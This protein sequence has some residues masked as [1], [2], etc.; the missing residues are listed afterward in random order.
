MNSRKNKKAV[1]IAGKGVSILGWVPPRFNQ[2]GSLE[3]HVPFANYE[4]PGT[5]VK[6]R[7]SEGVRGTT[8]TDEAARTHDIDYYNIGVKLR[9]GEISKQQ[10]EK[11][12]RESDKKLVQGALKNKLSIN[13]LENLHATLAATGI[14]AKMAGEELGVSDPLRFID[15]EKKIDE[16]KKE[17]EIK[18]GKS[19]RKHSLI[20][21]LK[22][23]CQ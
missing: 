1:I 2:K 11:L 15:A 9:N 8:R 16:A 13:P 18:G 5:D 17:E 12:V 20:K 21:N 10:A 22:K 6:R 4:G 3:C 19:S 7:V 23:R 14:I